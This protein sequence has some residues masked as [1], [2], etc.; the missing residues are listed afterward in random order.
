MNH[1]EPQ[2]LE[3]FFLKLVSPKYVEKLTKQDF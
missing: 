2:Q 3:E 1:G